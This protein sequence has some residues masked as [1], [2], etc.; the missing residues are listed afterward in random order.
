MNYAAACQTAFECPTDR[1]QIGDRV[2]RMCD[3]AEQTIVGYE[4]FHDVR[5][6]AFPEL[7]GGI[8]LIQVLRTASRNWRTRPTHSAARVSG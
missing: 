5:L 6:L 2:R 1:H 7:E 8:V 4:P 3:I